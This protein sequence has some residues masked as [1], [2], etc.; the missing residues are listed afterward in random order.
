M[1]AL[2][3]GVD[4]FTEIVR[5]TRV[6]PYYYVDKTMLIQEI[7]T[8][9]A[10]VTLIP[11]PRRFG[12][13]LNLDM[14]RRFISIGTDPSLFDGLEIS[15]DR[16]FC[17]AYLGQYPVLYFNFKDVRGPHFEDACRRLSHQLWLRMTT[18]YPF[19]KTSDALSPEERK[20]CA[21]Y[22]DKTSWRDEN[23]KPT[24]ILSTDQL[25][26][27]L[28]V[29][30]VFLQ[31]HYGR[32]VAVL[33]DEYDVPLN[34]AYHSKYYDEMVDLISSMFSLL[35]KSNDSMAFAVITGC[36]RVAKES[37][38]TGTNNLRVRSANDD[39]S[40]DYFGFTETEVTAMLEYYGIPEALPLVRKWYDGFKFGRESL[41][42]PWD[43]LQFVDKCRVAQSVI[44]PELYWANSSGNTILTRLL[45]RST[46]AMQREYLDLLAGGQIQKRISTELTFRDLK[47]RNNIWS[48]M[49]A[50]GY[51]TVVSREGQ[52]S[53]LRIPNQEV[54]DLFA[55]HLNEWVMISTDSD[56]TLLDDFCDA[57]QD[58]DPDEVQSSLTEI[59][60]GIIHQQD[61][62]RPKGQR[63][64]LYH[65]IVLGLLYHKWDVKSNV[66]SGLGF[67]DVS[68]RVSDSLGIVIE[69]KDGTHKDLG[70][71]AQGAL[72]Q[73]L[74]LHYGEDLLD[75]GC[76]KII[77]YGIACHGTDVAVRMKTE[78]Q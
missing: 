39:F 41:Y 24:R 15:G 64:A 33:I 65:G 35:L 44:E 12:K 43:V 9:G 29:L 16:A 54:R 76:T 56:E 60:S 74:R 28:Q 75:Q 25:E 78:I 57:F 7:M 4:S 66:E 19:L 26:T 42:C 67:S 69:M 23:G 52:L 62:R 10:Y 5:R 55:N 61:L 2:P 36:L 47:N 53:V 20:I 38:F 40:R 31:K 48:F 63:E 18:D 50:S 51:L 1:K 71:D 22:A 11:R 17:D 68:Y 70:V 8:S 32:K 6:P 30:T 49:V 3:V 27:S 13:T 45:S 77:Y 21:E 72:D 34:S 37:I 46:S 14:I 58:G 59:L 73:I